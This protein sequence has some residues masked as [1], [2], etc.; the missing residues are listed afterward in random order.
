MVPSRSMIDNQFHHSIFLYINK[1]LEWDNAPTMTNTSL[2]IN[3]ETKIINYVHL[4]ERLA[5]LFQMEHLRRF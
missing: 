5:F 1:L 2:H 4:Y 3:I